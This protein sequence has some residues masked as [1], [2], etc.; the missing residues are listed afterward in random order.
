MSDGFMGF[1]SLF[2]V[3]MVLEVLLLDDSAKTNLVALLAPDLQAIYDNI[4][5]YR[6]LDRHSTLS[7][8]CLV[9]LVLVDRNLCNSS[10][11]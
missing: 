8:F 1:L 11:S 10:S 4:R 9:R 7:N 3:L 5:L 2:R 6:G